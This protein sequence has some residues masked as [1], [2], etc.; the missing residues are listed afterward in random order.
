MGDNRDELTD[1]DFDFACEH[2]SRVGRPLVSAVTII[3][4]LVLAAC[5]PTAD[6]ADATLVKSGREA[7]ELV[8]AC[9]RDAGWGA[10]AADDDSVNTHVPRGQESQYES[11]S[12][13]CWSRVETPTFDDVSDADR[14]RYYDRFLELR[15]CLVGEGVELPPAPTYQAR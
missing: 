10:T 2:L 4:L 6:E 15:E 5:A 9:L 3:G 14:Q 11:A 12:E 7:S 1:D 8:A 13:A